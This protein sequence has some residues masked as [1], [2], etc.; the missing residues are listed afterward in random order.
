MRN[1]P[2]LLTT[3]ERRLSCDYPRS[4]KL[5]RTI[6]DFHCISHS[7]FLASHTGEFSSFNAIALPVTKPECLSF[8]CLDALILSCDKLVFS[9]CEGVDLL[10]KAA[11][12][13]LF[14]LEVRGVRACYLRWR[15]RHI[16][17]ANKNERCESYEGKRYQFDHRLSLHASRKATLYNQQE[18]LQG[19]WPALSLVSA[20]IGQLCSH[21]SLVRPPTRPP[22]RTARPLL[23][24]EPVGPSTGCF[25]AARSR[26]A[27]RGRTGS[28]PDLL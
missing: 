25:V 7:I 28:A 17:A 3:M 24:P 14:V 4:I 11:A 9:T 22:P 16:G 12:F 13:V 23:R 10:R 2:Q 5:Q 18:R 19:N 27:C 6:F 26:P 15:S 21:C 1:S 20:L 8:A